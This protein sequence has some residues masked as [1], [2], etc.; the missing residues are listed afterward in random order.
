M[1]AQAFKRKSKSS[2]WYLLEGVYCRGVG[3]QGEGKLQHVHLDGAEQGTGF[4]ND[5]V[6]V[7]LICVYRRAIRTKRSNVS[8]LCSLTFFLSRYASNIAVLNLSHYTMVCFNMCKDANEQNIITVYRS[9]LSCFCLHKTL[10]KTLTL[11]LLPR[12]L[13]THHKFNCLQHRQKK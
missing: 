4:L 10:A 9:V 6:I 8:S 3:S 13:H 12:G 5:Q 1:H 2:S 11:Q 7:C